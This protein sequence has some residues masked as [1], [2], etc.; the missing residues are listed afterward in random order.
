MFFKSKRKT[1]H[2]EMVNKIDFLQKELEKVNKEKDF[3]LND[4]K[5]KLKSKE[6]DLYAANQIV[7]ELL[8]IV[9]DSVPKEDIRELI[10]ELK[11][12][13]DMVRVTGVDIA[14]AKLN[15]ALEVEYYG[16]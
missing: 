14:I 2:Q 10:D 9:R 8:D 16:K 11:L 13:R 6:A 7:S 5:E 12:M 15:E 3:C 1:T 4:L